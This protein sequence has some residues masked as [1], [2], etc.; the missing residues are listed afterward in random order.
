MLSLTKTRKKNLRLVTREVDKSTEVL[1][2]C[3]LFYPELVSTGQTLTELAEQLTA[4]GVDVEVL[5][6]PPTVMV[7]KERLPRH[8]VHRDIHIHRVWGTQF[9]KL[10]LIGRVVNQLTFT[11]SVFLHLLLHRSNK[12]ILVL[13][14]PP[15]LAVTCGLLRSLRVGAPYV[16]LVFDVYPDTAV[17]LGILKRHGFVSRLW[18]R[19][20]RFVFRH[21][22]AIVV[23]GRCMHEVIS[24]KAARLGYPLNGK[25]HTIHIWS[26]DRSIAHAKRRENPL[27]D[28]FGTRG[29]F[30]VEYS[31]NMGRFHDMETIMG[32][33][34]LLKDRDDIVFLFVGEGHKKRRMMEFA[35]EKGLANCQFHTYVPRE[36]LGQLLSLAD[37]GLVSLVDGQEGLSVPS[38]TF[39]MMAAGVPIVAVMSDRS[40]IARIVE[41][42]ECGKVIRPG[43]SQSLA[44]AILTFYHDGAMRE[45]AGRRSASAIKS[46]YNLHEAA[47]E[48]QEL[49]ATVKYSVSKRT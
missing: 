2:L 8:L 37:V 41:E 12:P 24:D 44:D 27:T 46:K 26:D 22:S 36:E 7:T 31:G 43:E 40:E 48:Y 49:L 47:K 38:K 33:A 19:A 11:C 34:E 35:K 17:H 25:L 28:R 9:P 14:N 32:A 16:F 3:Q 13:T 21:A 4:F 45:A 10:S 29:K 30:V 42:E 18:D 6:G 15:F 39:G 23:I 20:N 1:I 5:C